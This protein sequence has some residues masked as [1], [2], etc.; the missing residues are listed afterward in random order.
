MAVLRPLLEV[1]RDATAA[2]CASHRLEPREDASNFSMSALRNR[3]RHRLLPQLRQYNPRIADALV[4][5]ADIVG[6]D[7]RWL[8][9]E[10]ERVSEGIVTRQG[11][12]VLL[13]KAGLLAL[14]LALQ[15]NLLRLAVGEL[16]ADLRGIEWRHVEDMLAALDLPAGRRICLPGGLLLAV[17]YHRYVISRDPAV[18]CPFPE[19]VGETELAV[20]GFSL[21]PGWQV[22]AAL[23]EPAAPPG[24]DPLT[25]Y[26]DPGKLSA[27]L[28]VRSRRAG[29]R[30]RPLGMD[31]PKK[32]GRFMID[33][34]V[35]RAWRERV[36]VVCSGDG[37][38]WVVGYRVDESFRVTDATRK[39]LRLTFQP[40][41]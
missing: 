31:R 9:A 1:G 26:L 6:E 4:R 15:R 21:L 14:P 37:I 38:I 30:F 36:P 16:T 11:H 40:V 23:A 3:I 18:L 24:G 41:P 8:D 12:A 34:H 32:V 2:Y 39:A 27:P 33:A 19:L 28:T 7:S 22:E 29:D 5:T 35:P 10:A 25:A 17:E 13:D 20:P